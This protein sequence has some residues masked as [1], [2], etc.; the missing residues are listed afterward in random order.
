MWRNHISHG[1]REVVGKTGLHEM[2]LAA[3]GG[4]LLH[5]GWRR[6][7]S[8]DDDGNRLRG[9]IR[10]E[11]RAD[12]PPRHVWKTE[13]EDD[14]VRGSLARTDETISA[15]V[16]EYH[17]EAGQLEGKLIHLDLVGLVIH[18]KHESA[19]GARGHLG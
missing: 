7:G 3:G 12:I 18:E 4:G 19:G 9:R 17:F 10:L 14:H 8:E 16:G 15:V 2:R 13:V 6:R 11:R 5:Q 1:P